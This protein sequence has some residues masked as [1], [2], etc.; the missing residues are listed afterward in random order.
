MQSPSKHLSGH[1][2]PKCNESLLE[3]ELR[4]MLDKHGI[5]Y[6]QEF[7]DKW[8][9]NG[10]GLQKIDFRINDT[11]ILIE[12]QGIQHFMNYKA[13]FILNLKDTI[14][15]D[16]R[17][18]RLAMENGFNLLYYV[19]EKYKQLTH[20]SHI[21]QDRVYYNIEDIIRITQNE[22]ANKCN[23]TSKE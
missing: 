4:M 19:P 10:K 17:K 14:E 6:T 8:L 16:E 22:L 21:Y 15:R 3:K 11:N 12:C 1:G 7:S 9:K 13:K 20:I 23:I 18:Y 5:K 2:C